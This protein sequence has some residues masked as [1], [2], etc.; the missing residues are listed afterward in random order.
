M[1]DHSTRIKV[2]SGILWKSHS[3]QRVQ[4]VIVLR[5]RFVE[6][7]DDMWYTKRFSAAPYVNCSTIRCRILLKRLLHSTG[8]TSKS[9][10]LTTT[11]IPSIA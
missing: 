2:E 11:P 7:Q 10:R 9:H 6:K 5:V 3:H 1:W 4:H 8:E